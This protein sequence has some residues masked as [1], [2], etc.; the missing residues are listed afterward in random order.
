MGLGD[1]KNSIVRA[2]AL[3]WLRGKAADLRQEGNPVLKYLDGNKRL[4]FCIL[5]CVAGLY[6]MIS[7]HDISGILVVV[8]QTTG[9]SDSNAL[10][11]GQ[12]FAGIFVPLAFAAWASLH[13]LYKGWKQWQAGATPLEINKPVGIVKLAIATGSVPNLAIIESRDTTTSTPQQ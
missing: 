3:R 5:F 9:F 13:G 8:L 10:A 4:L 1:L 6:H 12:T 2:L 7:G 11:V